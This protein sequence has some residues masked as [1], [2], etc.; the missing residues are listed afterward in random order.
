VLI[1]QGATD[2][3]VTPDQAEKLAAAFRAGGN[4]QVTVRIFPGLDHLFV[5]DPSG[6][7]ADYVSL[8]SSRVTPEVLGTIADWLA[9]KF[10]I[11]K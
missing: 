7:P 4:N 9:T 11:G 6:Q 10:G 2:H 1:L 3:Q 8:P 5:P